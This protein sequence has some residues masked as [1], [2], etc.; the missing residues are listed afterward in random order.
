[1]E[2]PLV[3]ICCVTYNH[4]N[5][6]RDCLDSFLMQKTNFQF[7]VIIHDDASTDNTAKIICEYVEKYPDLFVPI[8]QTDNQYSKGIK[9]YQTYVYPRAKGKYIAVCEGDDYWTDPYK[10]QKQ[11]D[12]LESNNDYVLTC[13]RYRKLDDNLDKWLCDDQEKLFENHLE[14]FTFTYP[15]KPWITK[16]LTLVFRSSALAAMSALKAKSEIPS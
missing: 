3:S 5:Y 10:L 12:F 16:T 11:V 7:E 9:P 15:F 8:L 4:E 13:H 2:K 14:G 6:I 1:M